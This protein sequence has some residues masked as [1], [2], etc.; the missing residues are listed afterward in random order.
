MVNL[1]ARVISKDLQNRSRTNGS[2]KWWKKKIIICMVNMQEVNR[3]M[4]AFLRLQQIIV[5]TTLQNLR[6][7]TYYKYDNTCRS[8]DDTGR[9]IWSNTSLWLACGSNKNGIDQ[10]SKPIRSRKKQFCARLKKTLF[11]E[12]LQG[13]I[14]IFWTFP[15]VSKILGHNVFKPNQGENRTRHSS[16][17]KMVVNRQINGCKNNSSKMFSSS[18]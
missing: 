17:W 1:H 18:F 15:G 5:K 4:K 12:D 9:R 6:I 10:Q 8:Q 2:S 13:S 7:K 14:Y 11:K 3:A 16:V